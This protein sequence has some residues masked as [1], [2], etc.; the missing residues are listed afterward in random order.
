MRDRD[1][2]ARELRADLEGQLELEV[3]GYVR[4]GQLSPQ[5]GPVTARRAHCRDS[6]GS[7]LSRKDVLSQRPHHL[8]SHEVWFPV[9]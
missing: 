7:S 4:H 5:R 2:R 1:D 6:A 9:Y 3:N 8:V